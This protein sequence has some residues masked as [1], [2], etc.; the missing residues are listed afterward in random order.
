MT[1]II[2]KTASKCI[3]CGRKIRVGEPINYGA[4]GS[5][6]RQCLD[7]ES[8]KTAKRRLGS[9]RLRQCPVCGDRDLGGEQGQRYCP[10]CGWQE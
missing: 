10:E 8:L 9:K 2:A 5:R 4:N 6:H 3:A 1:G 7:A